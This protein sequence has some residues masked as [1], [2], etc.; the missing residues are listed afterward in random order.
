[1]NRLFINY[2]DSSIGLS[3]FWSF[4]LLFRS[5]KF[6]VKSNTFYMLL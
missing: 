3:V 5:N 2:F 4:L 6:F 1:M